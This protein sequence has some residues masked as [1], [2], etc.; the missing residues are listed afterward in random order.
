MCALQD[1]LVFQIPVGLKQDRPGHVSPLITFHKETDPLL[2]V[3]TSLKEYI[4]RTSDLRSSQ[5]LFVT[6]TPPHGQAAKHTLRTW[7]VRTLGEAGIQAS[8]GSTRAAAASYAAASRVP[9]TSILARGDWARAS[10]FTNHY[11]RWFPPQTL[12]RLATA[13]QDPGSREE[14]G[15]GGT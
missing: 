5:F 1:K 13:P 4:S 9:L 3:F 15:G 12:Q 14:E 8:A 7:V 6:T 2:C 10:T 11:L